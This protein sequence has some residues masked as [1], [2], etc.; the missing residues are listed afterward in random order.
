M[1]SRLH[2]QRRRKQIP[3]APE[4]VSPTGHARDCFKRVNCSGANPRRRRGYALNALEVHVP[5]GAAQGQ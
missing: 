3:W 5:I 4:R 1:V 2:H